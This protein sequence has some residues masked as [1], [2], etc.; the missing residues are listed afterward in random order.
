MKIYKAEIEGKVKLIEEKLC[1]DMVTLLRDQYYGKG[2]WKPEEF[3][4]VETKKPTLFE[5]LKRWIGW[6]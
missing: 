4:Y 1:R 3:H 2:N 6:K 5:K